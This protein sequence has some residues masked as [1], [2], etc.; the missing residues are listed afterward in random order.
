MKNNSHKLKHGKLDSRE[1]KKS[2]HA[3][4]QIGKRVVQRDC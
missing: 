2:Y 3:D 1:K 4:D